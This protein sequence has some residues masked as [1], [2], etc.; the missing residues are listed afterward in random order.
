MEG[1]QKYSKWDILNAVPDP[2]LILNDGREIVSSNDAAVRML[3][4]VQAGRD[5]SLSLRHPEI[6][7]AAD[8]ALTGNNPDSFEVSVTFN[9]RRYLVV[10]ASSIEMED[11][12][13]GAMLIL[14]DVTEMHSA[15][16]MRADFV[17]NVSHELRSPLSSLS[18]FIETL[19]GPAKDDATARENFLRIM[20]AEAARMTRLIDD[21]LSLSKLEEREFIMPSGKVEL[22]E[23]LTGVANSLSVRTAERNVEILVRTKG[24]NFT[25]AGDLD[26]LNIV[27]QNLM[28]NA[29]SYCVGNSTV[30]VVLETLE[31]GQGA[32]V[33]VNNRGDVIPSELLPRLTER[34]YRIDK[35]R[36]RAMGGTGLGLAIVKHI[37][38]RHRGQLSIKSSE[39]DGTTFIVS[40]PL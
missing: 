27:F 5:L 6:L 8:A 12:K 4:S 37:V 20:E 29:I 1:I 18:G 25:V 33:S 2:V 38:N 11:E 30:S 15:E 3:G 24:D 7:A 40:L 16:Q 22:E 9:V 17:A 23:L 35:G 31:N 36:S 32:M 19:Q 28:D 34:F 26:E 14:R 13:M 21:L 39:E 10:K